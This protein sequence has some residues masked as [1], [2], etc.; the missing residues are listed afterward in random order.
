MTVEVYYIHIQKNKQ[1]MLFAKNNEDYNFLNR[2]LISAQKLG[3]KSDEDIVPLKILESSELQCKITITSNFL[4]TKMEKFS[5]SFSESVVDL[6][7][8]N[9][10]QLIPKVN[11]DLVEYALEQ[12]SVKSKF[13][14]WC[15]FNYRKKSSPE[16]I[17]LLQKE[18]GVLKASSPK[19]SPDFNKK[20]V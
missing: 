11:Y 14:S 15:L 9:D 4:F 18:F 16:E 20:Y 7:L 5:G 19:N 13:F 2:L 6:L 10:V 8:A 12:E 3:N 17:K 1:L